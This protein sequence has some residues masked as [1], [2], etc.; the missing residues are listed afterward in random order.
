[1]DLLAGPS[2]AAA[3]RLLP[4]VAEVLT[5][6]APWSGFRPPPVDND[7]VQHL[8]AT[9]RSRGY[10]AA[11]IFTSFHQ[12]PLPMALLCKMAGIPRVAATSE[13]YPGSLL[14]LRHRRPEGLHEVE[15][16]LD[17]ARATGARLAEGDE[18]RLAVRTPLPDVPG[19][20]PPGEYVVL[21]PGASVPSRATTV[22]H[23]AALCE[24]LTAA[25]WQV[26]LT[27]GPAEAEYA[28]AA[29]RVGVTDVVGRTDLA[30]L[31]AV[32]AQAACVVVGNTGPAHLAAA[33]GTPVVSLFAPVVPAQRWA[34]YGVPTIV[35]GDQQ[36]PCRDTRARECPV[37][38]HPCLTGI[39]PESVV[40][41]VQQ[42]VGVRV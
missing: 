25:G 39:T 23:A 16:M 42:L 12:S 18:G 8:V 17:L 22:E 40:A 37:G 24:A 26:V 7:A 29:Q 32:L 30:M 20:T 4:G 36:A 10:A 15:A 35:L 13:D 5:Y 11:V 41:A 31:A 1:V 19:L 28:T 6:H 33:V 14:D 34:P 3:A 21:H 2:G 27:G 38:G 9:L